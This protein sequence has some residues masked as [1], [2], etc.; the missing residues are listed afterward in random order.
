MHPL[1]ADAEVRH[2][3][4]LIDA[5]GV[6]DA[7]MRSLVTQLF[8]GRAIKQ[9]HD[10]NPL[11]ARKVLD[12]ELLQA[13]T[14]LKGPT[15]RIA[16]ELCEQFGLDACVR[17]LRYLGHRLPGVELPDRIQRLGNDPHI[18]LDG[19]EILRDRA[20]LIHDVYEVL[21]GARPVSDNTL[22]AVFRMIGIDDPSGVVSLHG[23][24][25]QELSR[26]ACVQPENSDPHATPV[27]SMP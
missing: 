8:A 24:G 15:D 25:G 14:L 18:R 20:P 16:R 13:R 2:L 12:A 19:Q 3:T 4:D 6:S 23:D 10:G 17:Q 7:G 22:L 5:A 26:A 1:S 27:S 11:N 9:T 21:S